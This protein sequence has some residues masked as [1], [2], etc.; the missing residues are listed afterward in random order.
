M[1]SL[2]CC[3]LSGVVVLGGDSM[4]AVVVFCN[5]TGVLFVLF[6]IFMP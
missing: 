3:R 1:G 4:H 6:L 2:L 5:H